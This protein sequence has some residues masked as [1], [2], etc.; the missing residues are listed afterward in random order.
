MD[1]GGG[2]GGGGGMRANNDRAIAFSCIDG[3]CIVNIFVANVS[4]SRLDSLTPVL[5]VAG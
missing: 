4:F 3:A 5:V 2:G 1:S